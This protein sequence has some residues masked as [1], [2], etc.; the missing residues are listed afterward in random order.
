MRLF[1]H[2]LAPRNHALTGVIALLAWTSPIGAQGPAGAISGQVTDARATGLASATIRVDGTRLEATTAADGR[3]RITNVPAGSR[4]VTVLRLGYTSQRRVVAVNAGEEATVNVV[5]QPG[6]VALEQVVVTGTA[7]GQEL[8]AIGNSVSTIRAADELSK[9]AAPDLTSLMRSRTT[10]LDVLPVSGR[11]GAGP[12]IQVRGPSSIGLANQPLIYVDGIRVNNAVAQ[13]PSGSGGL[14]GQGAQVANRLNDFNPE[15]I[16]RI[17]I[18]KGPAAAT[19]YGTEAANGVVQIIT[20]KGTAGGKPSVSVQ[21]TNGTTYF[22]DAA[23]RVPTNYMR[24]PANPTNIVTWNGIQQEADSGRPIYKNGQE[25][26]FLGSVSGGRDQMRY[27]LSA[28]YQN[29]QGIEP[30]NSFRQFTTHANIGSPISNNSDVALSLNF[31]NLT[32]HLGADVGASPLLGAIAGHR[33]LFPTFRGFFAAPPEVPQRLYDNASGVYQFTGSGTLSNQPLSWLRHRA[34]VG[35]DYTS[36]D[37]RGIEHF[38]TPPLNAF[39]S[40]ATAGGRIA[41]TLRRLAMITVDYGATAT[42]DVTST[43]SSSTS[44]GGQFNRQEFNASFLGGQGF[45][46]SGVETVTA[47]A[48]KFNSTQTDTTNTTIGAYGEEQLGWRD[49]LYLTAGFRIDNNSAFGDEF[50]SITYPKAAISWVASDEPFFKWD[51]WVSTLRL[52]AAY[53][54]SGRQPRAFSALRTFAPVTGPGGTNALTPSSLG[55]PELQ[56]ERGKEL[57]MGFEATLLKRVGFDFTSYNK[58]TFNVIV[59]QPVP[60]SSGFSGNQVVNLGRVD[61]KGIEMRTTYDTPVW[62]SVVYSGVLSVSTA[63]NTIKQNIVNAVTSIGNSNIIGYP[64]NGFWARQVVTAVINPLT[65]FPGVGTDS[66]LCR[67]ATTPV[68][69]PTAPFQFIGSATPKVFGSLSHTLTFG[70]DIRLFA[71]TDFRRGYKIWNQ[72]EYIRCIG[73]TGAPLCEQNYYPTRFDPVRL[74]G[75]MAAAGAANL[76]ESIQDAS[77]VKLREVSTTY[78]LPQRFIPGATRGSI[79]LAGQNLHTWTKYRGIDPESVTPSANFGTGA[80]EQAVTPPLTRFVATLNLT[81]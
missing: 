65:G 81:W 77:F 63:S 57:E 1:L 64:I 54:E 71:L 67:G 7:G 40:A 51:R 48:S 79:T 75:Y 14:G 21:M 73:L 32:S 35:I 17:E 59:N 26:H 52:R 56:P 68:P 49:R 69:C 53:G 3:Y 66:I 60:P 62:R 33:L 25:R 8:R 55:N 20:K 39:L 78:F 15:D 80:I 45:P 31:V 2:R 34:I 76:S 9:S 27:Y 50:K 44:I 22:Q 70:K 18:I 42:R 61:S 41:Q 5:L 72:N 23:N 30:N 38:A 11:V 19:I 74:A 46:A 37:A 16:E 36:D 28:G 6:A 24:D 4:S 43:L 12:A 29:D 10:G 13:G 47:A 58:H